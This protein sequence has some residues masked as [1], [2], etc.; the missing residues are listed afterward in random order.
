VPGR[1]GKTWPSCSEGICGWI[2]SFLFYCN[3][4]IRGYEPEKHT[5][6]ISTYMMVGWDPDYD[7]DDYVQFPTPFPY[8]KE[9]FLRELVLSYR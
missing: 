6:S 3:Y 5:A 1:E 4:C 8:A 2:K 7:T 9:S